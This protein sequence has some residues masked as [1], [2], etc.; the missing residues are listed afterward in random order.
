MNETTITATPTSRREGTFMGNKSNTK[1]FVT[2]VIAIAGL[3]GGVMAAHADT[4]TQRYVAGGSDRPATWPAIAPTTCASDPC[5]V[6]LFAGTGAVAVDDTVNGS[7]TVP[8]YGF[9]VDGGAV[10]LAGA[11]TSTIK[12]PEGTTLTIHLTQDA[13]ITD[14]IELS[15]PSLPFGAQGVTNNG[16]G[17]YTVVASKVGT[18]VFQP[19]SNP[20]AP[21]QVAMGLAGVLVVTPAACISPTLSCAYDAGV[22]YP[23]EAI[24]ATTDLDYAFATATDPASFDMSYFGQSRDAN[25]APR[26]VYHVINGK[27]FPDTDVIDA[28]AGDHVLLRYVNAG[29]TDKSI[30]IHGLR[31]SLVA[32]NASPY[33]DPQTLIAPL[34]GP[35]ET[36][37]VVVAIPDTIPPATGQRFSLLDQGRQMNHGTASGFGGALTFLNV[38][39]TVV[40]PPAVV[41][42]VVD[43]VSFA[44][45]DQ[46]TI[47]ASSSVANISAAEVSTGLAAGAAGS[48]TSLGGTFGA[49]TYT[50]VA[51]L[52]PAPTSGDTVWVR[53][54]DSNLVWS[55]AV[56]VS[57]P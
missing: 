28:Q 5:V 11:P 22:G 2:A 54:Q 14:P 21:R 43:S 52:A 46:L 12:V 24:V 31:E 57:V 13:A 51:T 45:P 3:T 56:S 36:A 33:T 49:S 1:R 20:D 29:V 55:D 4:F 17:S 6:D 25:D 34:V 26:Q 47:N 50:F 8:F 18:S 44:A 30:G 53:V 42:P 48:G 19:G 40:A 10:A 37:D 32:R 9:G 41:A 35:G 38:W 39:P 15:F 23:D 27:S 16:G 7:A